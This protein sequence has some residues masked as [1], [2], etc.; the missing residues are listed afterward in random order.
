MW[1]L[2]SPEVAHLLINDRGWTLQAYQRWLD[3]AL[4]DALLPR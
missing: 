4:T 2:L 3:Q 1:M